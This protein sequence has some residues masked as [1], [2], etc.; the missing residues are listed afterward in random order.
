MVWAFWERR[1]RLRAEAA[2]VVTFPK[3]GYEVPEGYRYANPARPAAYFP[4]V[5]NTPASVAHPHEIG[6]SERKVELPGSAT[7]V[8]EDRS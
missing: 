8:G 3:P 2:Q 4:H 7:T 1:Q 5:Y 6:P